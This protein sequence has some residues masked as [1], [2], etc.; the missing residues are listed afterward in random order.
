MGVDLHNPVLQ[1]YSSHKV[2]GTLPLHSPQS[3]AQSHLS[4]PGSQIWLPQVAKK[5]AEA[6]TGEGPIEHAS[7]KMFEEACSAAEFF[8]VDKNAK[9]TSN[10]MQK[11]FLFIFFTFLFCF[12]C[13]LENFSF[14]INFYSVCCNLVWN[15]VLYMVGETHFQNFQS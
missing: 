13:F 9:N 10:A 12:F 7:P 11:N 5:M 1:V 15:Q 4:S 8:A 6:S 3:V 2:F 14:R